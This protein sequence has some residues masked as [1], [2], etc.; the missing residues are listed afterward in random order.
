MS[1]EDTLARSAEIIAVIVERK[2]A[3]IWCLFCIY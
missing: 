3:E 1:R 2:L